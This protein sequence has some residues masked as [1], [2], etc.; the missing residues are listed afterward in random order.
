MGGEGEEGGGDKKKR[1]TMVKPQPLFGAGVWL[2]AL[3]ALAF[4]KGYLH[5][6]WKALH[7][8]PRLR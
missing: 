4:A 3:V 2:T 5:K 1:G 6:H 8:H 7:L